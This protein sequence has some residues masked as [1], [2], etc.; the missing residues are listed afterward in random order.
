M[1]NE[2]N[3]KCLSV[4]CFKLMSCAVVQHSMTMFINDCY[5]IHCCSDLNILFTKYFHFIHSKKLIISILLMIK[6]DK[7]YPYV[8]IS[9]NH[10][11]FNSASSIYNSVKFQYFQNQ[12]EIHVHTSLSNREYKFSLIS[13]HITFVLR[14]SQSLILKKKSL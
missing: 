6:K 10:L 3:I 14:N 13:L 8:I 9:N 12:L 11:Y 4:Y 7:N 1:S 2:W 5:D